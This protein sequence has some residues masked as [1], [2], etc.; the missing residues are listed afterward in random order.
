MTGQE[1]V[2]LITNLLLFVFIVASMLSMGLSLALKQIISQLRN[3]RLVGLAI[4]INFI[5]IPALAYGLSYVFSLDQPLKTGFIL[6]GV[7]AGA[8]FLPRLS[9]LARGNIAFSA[10]LMTAKGQ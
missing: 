2:T 10:G 9:Q 6:V 7:A 8:P 4:F 5:L 1:V 3:G